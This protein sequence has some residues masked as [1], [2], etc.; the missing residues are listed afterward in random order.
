M[1]LVA[2]G[3]I[4]G[5]IALHE[6]VTGDLQGAECLSAQGRLLP[7]PIGQLGTR[8]DDLSFVRMATTDKIQPHGGQRLAERH[9]GPRVRLPGISAELQGGHGH[10]AFR[11]PIGVLHHG[12]GAG[13]EQGRQMLGQQGLAAKVEQANRPQGARRHVAGLHHE[14]DHA[15]DG[16][17][18]SDLLA[19]D[20]AC[21]HQPV[22]LV[23]QRIERGATAEG[24][25]DIRHA[26]IERQV[27]M[28]RYTVPRGD[29]EAPIHPLCVAIDRLSRDHHALRYPR[30]AR[31]EGDIGKTVPPGQVVGGLHDGE[32][33]WIQDFSRRRL[34]R[35]LGNDRPLAHDEVRLQQ[36]GDTAQLGGRR[37][38]IQRCVIAA[39]QAGGDDGGVGIRHLR[40]GNEDPG[41]DPP[42]EVRC[43][44]K[45]LPRQHLV[46]QADLVDDH[47]GMLRPALRLAQELI[48]KIE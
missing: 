34:V 47:R 44:A 38:Q 16:V 12:V 29:A 46:T 18:D 26:D 31:R 2:F 36:S 32:A 43:K 48:G 25:D 22:G 8:D 15:R 11:R 17:P 41:I 23:E 6:S 1:A 40:Q 24:T 45:H 21:G 20:H 4:A 30:G 37:G 10:R 14:A 13:R 19:L 35:Q 9:G 3:P 27:G 33:G 39:G 28:L 42:G 5:Q 7:I